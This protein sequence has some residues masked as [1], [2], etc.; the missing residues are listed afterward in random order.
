M[1]ILVADDDPTSSL[2]AVTML[3]KLGHQCISAV[4]GTE[5]WN[6]FQTRRP[7]VLISDWLMPGLSGL[8]L[9]RKIRSHSARYTYF[10]MVTGQDSHDHMLEGMTAGA[11]DYLVK[12]LTLAE[13]EVR[14]IAAERVTSL[15]RQLAHQR[16]KLASVAR[17]EAVL[18]RP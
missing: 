2:I 4:D 18:R 9:C 11:D 6:A 15:H 10:I 14:L 13:L 7:D 16:T 8:E 17:R 1:L 5:A 12:P 3:R